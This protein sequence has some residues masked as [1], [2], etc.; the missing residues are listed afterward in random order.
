MEFRSWFVRSLVSA[1]SFCTVLL[2]SSVVYVLLIRKRTTG[3][4][5]VTRHGRYT[6]HYSTGTS[7]PYGAP[8]QTNCTYTAHRA[9]TRTCYFSNSKLTRKKMCVWK[10]SCL[11]WFVCPLPSHL[12]RALVTILTQKDCLPSSVPAPLSA[13]RFLF[14][15]K[16][17]YHIPIRFKIRLVLT[18]SPPD[19]LYYNVKLKYSI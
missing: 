19:V 1:L 18:G 13:R 15:S 11:R 10:E 2:Y 12:F 17:L 8:H 16:L 6:G 9:G 14:A 3:T 5:R 7:R 4:K